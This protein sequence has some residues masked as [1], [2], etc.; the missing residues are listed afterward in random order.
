M[1]TGALAIIIVGALIIALLFF[2][3]SKLSE[4]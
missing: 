2:G 1:N 4:E 3:V